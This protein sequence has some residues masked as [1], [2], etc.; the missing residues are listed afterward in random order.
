VILATLALA[1]AQ[2]QSILTVD[3]EHRLIEG[4]ATDGK[5]IW[6]SSLVDRQI[7]AC[8]KACTT[9]AMLPPGLH[10][11]AI[12]W[13]SRA[14][15]L[16]VAADCP[17]GVPFIAECERGALLGLDIRGKVRARVAPVGGT[18]HPGDVTSAN[19]EVF[20]SDSQNG[21]VYRLAPGRKSL[22]T[23]V[24]PGVGKSGQG[25]ALS[26]DGKK[27]IVADYSQGIAAVDLA[28]GARTLLPRQDGKPLRGV[29]GL[30][31]CGN[32]YLGLYNG[33]APG[34]LLTIAM[35][36][37]GVE[38]GELIEGLE[39]P[40]PTQVA[41]DGNRLLVVANSGWEP[42]MKDK[43]RTEGA[44][45]LAIPLGKDCKPI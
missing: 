19:G 24:A 3:P 25:T 21:A 5:I 22:L 17:P 37:G 43:P 36:P 10:P 2:P 14:K 26:P 31:R 27:L 18:F 44:P 35:R 8:G 12:S 6:L 9:L 23:L 42:A 13:D 38:Y 40:D 7:L 15:R 32:T 28:T 11:F 30:V 34:R 16:W 45:I 41:Y 20:V 39:L 33:A 29:D 1:A 4:I